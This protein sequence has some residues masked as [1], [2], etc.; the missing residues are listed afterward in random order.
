MEWYLTCQRFTTYR[1]KKTKQKNG[2]GVCAADL[3]S[4]NH[5]YATWKNKIP[6][7]VKHLGGHFRCTGR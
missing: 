7:Q 1:N 3:Q 4:S 5:T 6:I 2:T